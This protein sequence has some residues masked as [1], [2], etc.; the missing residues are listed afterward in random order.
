MSTINR[1]LAF[2]LACLAA[3]GWAGQAVGAD[4]ATPAA[5]APQG[6]PSADWP[7]I[8]PP[9]PSADGAGGGPPSEAAPG[10]EERDPF[11]PGALTFQFMSG[12]YPKANLGPP[13]D[14]VTGQKPVIDYLPQAL[15]LGVICNK[16][17]PEWLLLHGSFE[18]LLEY[19]YSAVVSSFGNYFTGPNAILRYNLVYPH[20]IFIPY[21]QGGAGFCLN[22]VYHNPDQRLI[23]EA[24]EFLLRGELGVRLMITENLSLDVEGGW[25]H[26]SNANL[27]SR[28]AGLNCLGASIGL[29]FFF[30]R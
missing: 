5:P 26:I 13:G 18:V 25:Q 22:D 24:F 2:L 9:A 12:Y 17:H 21:I 11:A 27:A 1:T 30:G 10:L 28:N 6:W 3:V 20:C 14:T 29:T 23:G 16:P 15:R 19:N 7:G 4:G 8:E